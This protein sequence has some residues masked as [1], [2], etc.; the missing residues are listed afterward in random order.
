MSA[1]TTGVPPRVFLDLDIDGHRAAHQRAIDF[2]SQCSIKYGLSSPHIGALGGS[3]RARLS[4]LYA[5]DHAWSTRGR[6]ELSPAPCERVVVELFAKEAPNCVT[7]FLALCTGSKGKAK[8]SGLP[9]HYRGSVIHRVVAGQFIQGGDFT[10]GNGAGGESVWGAPFKDEKESLK[11]KID[12]PGLLCMSNTGKHANSSQF[13]ITLAP[14]PKLT[15]KHCVFGRVVEGFG[16][17]EAVGRLPA[18]GERPLKQVIIAECG[19]V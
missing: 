19:Q 11:I 2:V 1:T 12:A 8:G 7:N 4:E 16:V 10:H 15:G 6:I 9:L 18:D 14:L 3:E 13:F 5:A 17:L